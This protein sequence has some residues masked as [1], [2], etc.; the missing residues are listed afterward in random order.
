MIMLFGSLKMTG[1]YMDTDILITRDLNEVL[2]TRLSELATSLLS[3]YVA[4]Y[5]EKLV[6]GDLVSS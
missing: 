5:F 2:A 4:T 3:T 1:I 6:S